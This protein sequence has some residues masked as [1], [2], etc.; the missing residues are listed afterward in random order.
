MPFTVLDIEPPQSHR[1]LFLKDHESVFSYVND[2]QKNT[3]FVGDVII[4]ILGES[5]DD[6]QNL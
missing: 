6:Y 1:K 2:N 4:A 3:L 5:C